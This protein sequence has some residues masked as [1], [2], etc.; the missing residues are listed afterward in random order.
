[1]TYGYRVY[2]LL[3]STS[4]QKKQD[5]EESENRTQKSEYTEIHLLKKARQ[6]RGSP[7]KTLPQNEGTK[8]NR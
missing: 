4:N 2:M 8:K 5:Y 3:L 7:K 1:M 6:E